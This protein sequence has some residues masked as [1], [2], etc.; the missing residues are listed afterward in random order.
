MVGCG[1]VM[2]LVA[3]WWGALWIRRRRRPAAPAPQ[4]H[5]ALLVAVTVCGPLGF[6]AIEAGWAVTEVGRQP[7]IVYGVV[8]TSEAVTPMTGLATPFA[9]VGVVYGAL[10]LVVAVVLGR[11]FLKTGDAHVG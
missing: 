5:R 7:W 2:A 3:L 4:D 1:S 9:L 11:L 10:G 6:L 8:R